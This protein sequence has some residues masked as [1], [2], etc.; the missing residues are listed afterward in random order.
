MSAIVDYSVYDDDGEV[1]TTRIPQREADMYDMAGA[2]TE[3][4]AL[5]DPSLAQCSSG[6]RAQGKK[7]AVWRGNSTYRL[8][9]LCSAYRK[10]LRPKHVSELIWQTLSDKLY[11][12]ADKLDYSWEQVKEKL[13]NLKSQYQKAKRGELGGEKWEHY[14]TMWYIMDDPIK[15]GEVTLAPEGFSLTLLSEQPRNCELLGSPSDPIVPTTIQATELA[16]ESDPTGPSEPSAVA[17]IGSSLLPSSSEFTSLLTTSENL[18]HNADFSLQ[19]DP[20]WESYSPLLSSTQLQLTELHSVENYTQI[21]SEH[22]ND[23]VE[24]NFLDLNIEET[25]NSDQA[26]VDVNQNLLRSPAKKKYQRS[27][28]A[29]QEIL[30]TPQK[31]PRKK[32]CGTPSPRSLVQG[33]TPTRRNIC[34][35][36]DLVWPPSRVQML[37][38]ECLIKKEKVQQESIP[39]TTWKD[40][41]KAMKEKGEQHVTW[42]LCRGK[43]FS[44][45]EYFSEKLLY[46]GGIVGGVK[47]PYYDLMCQIHD[48]PVDF[49]M[50]SNAA[51]TSS[52]KKLW[53]DATIRLLISLY[54]SKELYFNGTKSHVRHATLFSEISAAMG[55][56]GVSLTGKQCGDK[57]RDLKVRY[58]IEYD[59]SHR[60]GAAPSTWPYF[61]DMDALFGDT[62]SMKAPFVMSLGTSSKYKVGSESQPPQS[63]TRTRASSESEPTKNKKPPGTSTSGR[64]TY[65]SRSVEAH[66]TR[67]QQ[68]AR[69]IDEMQ[70]MRET[71]ATQC[72]TQNELLRMLIRKAAD[73]TS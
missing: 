9:Q 61:K 33:R 60:T 35:Q 30:K 56:H 39:V 4:S 43:F 71:Y 1:F 49:V 3:P 68:Q 72:E 37:L 22:N 62:A 2:V 15:V 52:H 6:K 29:I 55:P 27:D 67:V 73:K 16:C 54:K 40:I 7:G 47:A 57:F 5:A 51:Q 44:L 13:R 63:G 10:W 38:K 31:T 36:A 65:R 11:D 14:W 12:S 34:S 20:N 45:C 21:Q 64:A 42:E 28:G 41:A 70:M 19:L 58:R 17:V 66:E 24:N 53:D 23:E 32:P 8:L 50:P 26:L 25:N 69:I 46:T 48:I 59:E 18:N